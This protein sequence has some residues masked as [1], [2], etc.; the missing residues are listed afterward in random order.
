MSKRV[1]ITTKKIHKRERE[2]ERAL[3]LRE[4]FYLLVLM[5]NFVLNADL[6]I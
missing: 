6:Q 1:S 5:H 4:F 2:R 3:M